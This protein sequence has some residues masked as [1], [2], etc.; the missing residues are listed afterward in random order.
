MFWI[1]QKN[2]LH[3]PDKLFK[4]IIV[5]E[6]T[7]KRNKKQNVKKPNNQLK[8]NI[9]KYLLHYQQVE[10]NRLFVQKSKMTCYFHY[11]VMSDVGTERPNT[12]RRL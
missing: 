10:N 9:N 2:I 6:I 11:Q 4:N 3:L 8:G 5:F 7:V 12:N 1:F